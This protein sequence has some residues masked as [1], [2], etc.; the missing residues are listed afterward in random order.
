LTTTSARED[1]P[2]ISPDGRR[3]AYISNRGGRYQVFVINTDGSG[4]RQLTNE[5][6]DDW[7]PSF[8][9]DG[10]TIYYF[11]SFDGQDEVMAMSADGGNVRR[12]TNNGVMDVLPTSTPSGDYVLYSS[13]PGAVYQIW[14]MRADGGGAAPIITANRDCWYQSISPDGG[15]I[16]YTSGSFTGASGIAVANIDGSG[17][18]SLTSPQGYADWRPAFSPDG[19]ALAFASNRDGAWAIYTM[20][21]DGG[22]ATRITGTGNWYPSW[23]E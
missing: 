8:S 15:R 12:L 16:A 6:Y 17:V 13:R 18:R 21:A 9:R 7:G 14:R 22:A 5:A 3:V 19:G 2:S 23:G 1:E 20:S 10:R 4:E 11:R